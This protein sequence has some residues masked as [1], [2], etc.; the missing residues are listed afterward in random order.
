MSKGQIFLC[1]LLALI[2]FQIYKNIKVKYKNTWTKP[3]TLVK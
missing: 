2:M 1:Y 3:E